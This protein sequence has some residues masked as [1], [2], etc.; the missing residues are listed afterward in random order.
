MTEAKKRKQKKCRDNRRLMLTLTL[1]KTMITLDQ[2]KTVNKP[3][4]IYCIK[5]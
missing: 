4:I 2:T 5:N 1:N 3:I